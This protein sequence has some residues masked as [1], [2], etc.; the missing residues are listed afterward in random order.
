MILAECT[1]C[2]PRAGCVGERSLV[3]E[4]EW[5]IVLAHHL[6]GPSV[7]VIDESLG[8]GATAAA[9]ARRPDETA[10]LLPLTPWDRLE[11]VAALPV[12]LAA[13]PPSRRDPRQ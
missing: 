3:A 6:Y 4:V 7:L 5:T 2:G 9:A 12:P 10:D 11:R 8:A 13:G 1:S